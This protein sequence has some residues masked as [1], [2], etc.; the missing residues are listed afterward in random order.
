MNFENIIETGLDLKHPVVTSESAM[1][2]IEE[3]D[4]A[5]LEYL[6][7]AGDFKFTPAKI[8]KDY[9]DELQKILGMK[10]QFKPTGITEGGLDNQHWSRAWDVSTKGTMIGST[11]AAIAAT[12]GDRIALNKAPNFMFD[13]PELRIKIV[14]LEARMNKKYDAKTWLASKRAT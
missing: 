1:R 5:E 9:K 7:E 4:D 2:V 11:S 13:A 8:Y 6:S 12:W 3:I 10:L 14:K